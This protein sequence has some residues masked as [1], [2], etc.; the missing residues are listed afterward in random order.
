LGCAN[1]NCSSGVLYSAASNADGILVLRHAVVGTGSPRKSVR[2]I[3]KVNWSGESVRETGDPVGAVRSSRLLPVGSKFVFA[4]FDAQG[5]VLVRPLEGEGR[6]APSIPVDISCKGGSLFGDAKSHLTFWCP[7]RN[8]SPPRPGAHVF[9]FDADFRLQRQQLIPIIGNASLVVEAAD[10]WLVVGAGAADTP[11]MPSGLF[12]NL[13][14]GVGSSARFQRFTTDRRE[15][16]GAV[17][18]GTANEIVAIYSA[19]QNSADFSAVVARIGIE[20]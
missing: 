19:Q 10:G 3:Q 5:K 1:F 15:I 14:G 17:W 12:V 6:L 20:Q 11:D 9:G 7:L 18:A 4:D 16:H 8:E 2:I 13:A